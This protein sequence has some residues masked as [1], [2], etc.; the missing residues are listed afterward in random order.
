MLCK[1]CGRYLNEGSQICDLCGGEVGAK[2][3]KEQTPP[4]ANSTHQPQVSPL[5]SP[6][7]KKRSC[8][9]AALLV[10]GGIF[11]LFSLLII[12]AIALPDD[13]ERAGQGSHGQAHPNIGIEGNGIDYIARIQGFRAFNASHNISASFGDIVN[14]FFDSPSWTYDPGATGAVVEVRGTLQGMGEIVTVNSRVT[15]TADGQ[16]G[17]NFISASFGGE[18][19]ENADAVRDFLLPLFVAYERGYEYPEIMSTPEQTPEPIA[20]PETTPVSTPAATAEPTPVPTPT[21]EPTPAVTPTP[22][23][24]VMDATKFSI[25]SLITL[26]RG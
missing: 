22:A 26:F 19:F 13:G 12:L 2:E 5:P 16:V 14:A 17:L 1:H 21:P 6:E 24:P 23:A 11:A 10:I 15:L 4:I 8:L 18:T 7:P 9:R 25:F 3:T 20:A